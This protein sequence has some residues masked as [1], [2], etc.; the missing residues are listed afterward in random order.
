M[1][2]PRVCPGRTLGRRM[3]IKKTADFLSGIGTMHVQY[4]VSGIST[5]LAFNDGWALSGPRHVAALSD[6][7]S[8]CFRRTCFED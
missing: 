3:Y 2:E 4:Q 6:K 1:D 7:S 5:C 8:R